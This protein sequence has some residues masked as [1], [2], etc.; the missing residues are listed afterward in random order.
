MQILFS[1]KI[2]NSKMFRIFVLLFVLG[3][4]LGVVSYFII[5][6]NLYNINIVNYISSINDGNISYFD[7]FI[8]S[9]FYKYLFLFLIFLFGIFFF[10][11]LFTP[12]FIIFRGISF[13]ILFMSILCVFKLKGILLV[14][15]M[16]CPCILVN[17]LIYIFMS[18][19]SYNFASKVYNVVKF[20]KFINIK[21]FSKNYFSIFLIFSFIMILNILFDVYISSNLISFVV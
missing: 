7:S 20:D 11:S 8:T 5:D 4:V 14:L 16:F 13:G 12:I 18:Y 10:C 17:E 6:S 19:Y 2:I 9:F 15:I 1:M 21:R 3:F